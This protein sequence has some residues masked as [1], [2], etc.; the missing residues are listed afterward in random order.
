M[1][2]LDIHSPRPDPPAEAIFKQRIL[3][4]IVG[5]IEDLLSAA[6]CG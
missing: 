4:V 1:I 2:R 3:N 6:R 5:K